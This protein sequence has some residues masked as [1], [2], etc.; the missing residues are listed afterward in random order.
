MWIIS[1]LVLLWSIVVHLVDRVLLILTPTPRDRS[2]HRSV[3]TLAAL[4][5]ATLASL[6]SRE[7]GEA[8]PHRNN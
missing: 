3:M 5:L 1:C 7:T 4:A 6:L 8:A 2:A